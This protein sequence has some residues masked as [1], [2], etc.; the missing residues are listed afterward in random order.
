MRAVSIELI[1]F[2]T[3]KR[4]QLILPYYQ[5][6]L[7]SIGENQPIKTIKGSVFAC[8]TP[9]GT[10]SKDVALLLLSL[11]ILHYFSKAPKEGAAKQFRF[12]TPPILNKGKNDGK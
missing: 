10:K 9:S 12:A 8:L 4:M 6:S 1:F 3:N 7:C 11:S 5:M 2:K